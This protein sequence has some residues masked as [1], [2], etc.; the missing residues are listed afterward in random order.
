MPDPSAPLP[1]MPGIPDDLLIRPM[2]Q[3]DAPQVL[4]MT[5]VQLDALVEIIA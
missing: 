1:V 2:V 3:Q 4:A 5:N